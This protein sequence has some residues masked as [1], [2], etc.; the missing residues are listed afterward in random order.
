MACILWS[1]KTSLH[2][3]AAREGGFV[4]LWGQ[5]SPKRVIPAPENKPNR[6]DAAKLRATG[7]ADPA[8][9]AVGAS[10]HLLSN[11]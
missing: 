7:G 10:N 1:E 6:A 3:L 4:P 5:I 8:A 2:L 9:H 11:H